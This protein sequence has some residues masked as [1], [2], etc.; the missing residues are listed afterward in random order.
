[1]TRTIRLA[2]CAAVLMMSAVFAPA[3]SEVSAA[4][5]SVNTWIGIS[6]T[7]PAAGCVLD[8]SVEMVGDS[9]PVSSAAVE[10]FLFSYETLISSDWSVTDENGIAWFSIDTGSA[11]EAGWLDVTV[12]GEYFTGTAIS[13]ASG[14]S[15]DAPYGLLNVS[16]SVPTAE[17]DFV[18][19]DAVAGTGGGTFVSGV[20]FYVQQRNL[21]CE[22]ASLYIA[23][24]AY[25]NGI[26]EYAFDEVVGWS[27]N[28]HW[29]YRGDITGWWGNT[30]DYGVYAEPLAAALP[31]FG[32]YGE[33][34]YSGGDSSVL[35]S[36][37]DADVPVV[38]WL[39]LW[40]D[41]RQYEETDGVSYALV[42]G[43]HVVVAYGYDEG[44]VYVSDPAIGGSRYYA[45]GDFLYMWSVLDGM[46]L[47]VYP[48]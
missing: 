13:L 31:Y 39:S 32:F 21:S 20:P 17:V 24:A 9:G 30:Y 43:E 36:L 41:L 45:W 48:A 26:S 33:V 37:I 7:A 28:P 38:V 35:T 10:V 4:N 44:G 40:G 19:S 3:A 11:T 14:S 46:S 15:C 16:G 1:M 42:P 23:T 29:G 34:I 2:M 12:G 5:Q 22:Y 8:V 27:P 47:A 25:G 18:A 6:S